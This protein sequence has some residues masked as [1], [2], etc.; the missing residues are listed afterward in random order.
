M[1]AQ[2]LALSIAALV[3]AAGTGYAA[4]A[5]VS[6]AR[7]RK[8]RHR[9]ALGAVTGGDGARSPSR[10]QGAGLAYAESITRKFYTGTTEALSPVVRLGHVERTRPGRRYL[11][12]ARAAGCEK[13]VS[14]PAFCEAQ[15]RLAL[16]GA[17]AGGLLGVAFSPQ[18]ALLLCAAGL[19]FG[20]TAPIRSLEL[21]CKRRAADADQHLSEMLEVVAL[22][23]RSGLS[24]DLSF[25]LYG[26][27]FEGEFARSCGLAYRRWALG[28]MTREESLRLLASSYE[29]EQLGRFVDSVVRSLRL[30][31]SL[32]GVLEEAAS[33]SRATYRAAL[34]ERVAKAPV[35]MMLPT[36]TLILPAM[37]LMV[38]GPVLLELAGGF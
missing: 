12:R 32:A 20:Y 22:G 19:A 26:D 24:F 7:V 3:A 34:E 17:G 2:A 1:S 8:R 33:Q 5:T 21:S 18:M 4:F 31:T 28:L 11:D 30:G 15:F 9:A 14:A 13:E 23:L 27:H 35:K 37:L 36:G 6:A 16:A 38:M 25:A 10:L 29:C